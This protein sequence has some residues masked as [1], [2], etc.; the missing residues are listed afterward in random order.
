MAPLDG[1]FAFADR[2]HCAVLVGEHLDLD[3][4]AGGEVA[5]AEH[6]RVAERRLRL[7]ARRL[8]LRRQ[9]G[10]F[11]HHPHAAAAAARRRLDQHG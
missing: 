3:V 6:R 8:D 11:A 5:L 2:P 1:A 4:V 10:Q 9:F 7:A